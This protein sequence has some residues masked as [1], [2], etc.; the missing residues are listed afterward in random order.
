MDQT[1]RLHQCIDPPKGIG[2]A[3]SIHKVLC[4]LKSLYGLKQ[5]PKTFFDKLK[6]GL[7]ERGFEKSQ[8]DACLLM[9][10]NMI[11]LVYVDDTILAS[12]DSEVI[13]RKI[14]GLGVSTDE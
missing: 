14:T 12:P 10:K 1:C 11:C 8:M 6:A 9:K 3:D 13:E 5:A 4:L 7:E 2:G